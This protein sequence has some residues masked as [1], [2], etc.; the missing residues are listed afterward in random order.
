MPYGD[1]TEL[2]VRQLERRLM[3]LEARMK[4]KDQEMQQLLGAIVTSPPTPSNRPRISK[5][6][7]TGTVTA[8]SST[9]PGSGNA[10]LVVGDDTALVDGDPITLYN[11]SIDAIDFPKY[12][13]AV[14][15]GRWWAV[16]WE[17]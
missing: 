17:C 2:R 15:I 1:N 4:R 5:I 10:V 12:G 11:V 9:T 13:F 14:W 8:R 6:R 16:S 7:T 3:E